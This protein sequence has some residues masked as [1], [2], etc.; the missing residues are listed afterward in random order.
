[1]QLSMRADLGTSNQP[2]A[3]CQQPAASSQR[4]VAS[5]QQP[6]SRGEASEPVLAAF[7]RRSHSSSSDPHG[8]FSQHSAWP[9][10]MSERLNPP[11][12]LRMHCVFKWHASSSLAKF[13]GS[14]PPL[15][16]PPGSAYSGVPA[17]RAH[18]SATFT[19]GN[20]LL[21]PAPRPEGST[22]VDPFRS[23]AKNENIP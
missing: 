6:A 2:E 1:M 17:Q 18:S 22:A 3:I 9:G 15:A 19:A 13:L 4:P 23:F 8:G 7:D 16:P 10:G 14:L 12:P 5:S 21:P 11:H 20:T